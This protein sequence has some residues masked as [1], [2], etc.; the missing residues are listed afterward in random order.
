[1]PKPFAIEKKRSKRL[2]NKVVYI[3]NSY[4]HTYIN[5]Q[6]QLVDRA[7]TQSYTVQQPHTGRNCEYNQYALL[8]LIM[9]YKQ[10]DVVIVNPK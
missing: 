7:I 6:T 9:I 3:R 1:M 2:H 8:N 5:P 4:I 10:N